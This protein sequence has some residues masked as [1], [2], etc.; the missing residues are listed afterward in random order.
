MTKIM[1]SAMGP[2]GGGRCLARFGDSVITG[3]L[4]RLMRVGV[5][6]L[7]RALQTRCSLPGLGS[8]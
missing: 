2:P 6:D 7:R 4:C 8:T 5:G 1:A 3:C